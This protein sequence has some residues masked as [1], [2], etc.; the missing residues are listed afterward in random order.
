MGKDIQISKTNQSI[1]PGLLNNSIPES[2][3]SSTSSDEDTPPKVDGINSTVND[4]HD[5]NDSSTTVNVL[6]VLFI[7][8]VALMV[9]FIVYCT[10][11]NRNKP[12]V[13]NIKDFA[14]RYKAA[15]GTVS[16]YEKLN[17]ND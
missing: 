9:F 2:D 12:K 8:V 13:V 4:E 16:V 14:S 15:T 6:G 1:I 3:V 5:K 11:R 10:I 7:I 17:K